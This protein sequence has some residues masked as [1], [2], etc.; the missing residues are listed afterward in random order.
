MINN[1]N[2]KPEKLEPKDSKRKSIEHPQDDNEAVVKSKDLTY[3]KEEE[4]FGDIAKYKEQREQPV[5]PVK[6]APK[7]V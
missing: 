2:D 5:L 1:Q 6:E 7:D 4:D 3:T